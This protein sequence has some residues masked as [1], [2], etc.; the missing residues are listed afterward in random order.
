MDYLSISF[1]AK[2][3]GLAK[4]FVIS[5]GFAGAPVVA[6]PLVEFQAGEAGIVIVR[7]IFVTDKNRYV[8]V[9]DYLGN[10]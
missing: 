2:S 5:V 10:M 9:S 3:T 7:L 6:C 1:M 8:Y 4:K